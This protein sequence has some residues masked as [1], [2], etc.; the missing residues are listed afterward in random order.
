VT[1]FCGAVALV[2]VVLTHPANTN[3]LSDIAFLFGFAFLLGILVSRLPGRYLTRKAM[4][5]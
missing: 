3:S 5:G 4:K 2:V 1:A